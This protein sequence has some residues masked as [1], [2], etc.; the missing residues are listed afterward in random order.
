MGGKLHGLPR[1]FYVGHTTT[2]TVDHLRFTHLKVKDNFFMFFRQ[3]GPKG[4]KKFH[5][6]P[7]VKKT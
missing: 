3:G 7:P 1:K 4:T 6:V 5:G 2:S